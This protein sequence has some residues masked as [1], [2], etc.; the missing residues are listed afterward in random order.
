MSDAYF[1]YL[2]GTIMVPAE[3]PEEWQKE[4]LGK[5]YLSPNDEQWGQSLCRVLYH[6]SVHFWQ[7]FSS[8]YIANLV[9]DDWR[10]LQHYEETGEVLPLSSISPA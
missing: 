10:R 6:E 8:A 3:A 1:E 7:L 4:G 2:T 9:S 5:F